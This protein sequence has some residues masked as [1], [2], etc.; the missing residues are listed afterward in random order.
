MLK[1]TAT[2][3]YFSSQGKLDEAVEAYNKSIS[4]KPDYAET[5]NNLGLLYMIK[6]KLDEAIKHIQ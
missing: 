4:L 3:E 2:W 1:P 6:R 5:Y